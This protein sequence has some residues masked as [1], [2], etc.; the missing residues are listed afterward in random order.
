MSL[1]H[2]RFA[3]LVISASATACGGADTTEV[4]RAEP[5]SPVPLRSPSDDGRETQP[6]RPSLSNPAGP[7]GSAPDAGAAAV[8]DNSD[9]S[10]DAGAAPDAACVDALECTPCIDY[11]MGHGD[12]LALYDP[13]PERL[14]L[15]LRSH[16]TFPDPAGAPPLH[17]P[18]AVCIVVPYS[19]Y[20]RMAAAGGR[21]VFGEPD[22]FE[23]I[24]VEPG[25]AFWV[26]EAQ[27]LGSEQPFFGVAVD[28][29]PE[30]VF[31][32]PLRFVVRALSA[33]S[34]AHVS[35]YQLPILPVFYVSTR[36]PERTVAAQSVSL[37]SGAHD[38]FN[39]TFSHAGDYA[40]EMTVRGER[41]TGG[42]L[43][44]EAITLRFRVEPD[45]P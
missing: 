15:R 44:S 3:A 42:A 4:L 22:A 33:P 13:V 30:A 8:P 11:R 10:S 20:E 14:V 23:P 26:L 5:T 6:S 21:P 18:S 34:N 28:E 2:V 27:N 43:E 16:L 45:A 36:F 12:I 37:S 29:L 39:W 41:V 25:A 7:G 19:A 31:A 32:G 24:G 38:H 35:I 17:D 9:P 40:M 1:R